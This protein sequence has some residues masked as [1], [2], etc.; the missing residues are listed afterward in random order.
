M[1]GVLSDM[2]VTV[3]REQTRRL[4]ELAGRL[5]EN[6]T[7]SLSA[8]GTDAEGGSGPDDSRSSPGES[9]ETTVVEPAESAEN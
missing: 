9:G 5:N 6:R 8:T 3:N 2:M 4:E 1:F 7:S